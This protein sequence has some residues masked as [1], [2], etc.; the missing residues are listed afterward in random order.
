MK[1]NCSSARCAQQLASLIIILYVNEIE[2]E[3]ADRWQ[4]YEMCLWHA[5][6]IGF[7]NEIFSEEIINGHDQ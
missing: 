2:I 3:I 4:M 5:G 7:I 1:L 6:R